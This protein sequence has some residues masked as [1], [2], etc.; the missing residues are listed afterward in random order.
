MRDGGNSIGI[1]DMDK[2]AQVQRDNP[3]A[4]DY[5]ISLLSHR[6][7]PDTSQRFVTLG[8]MPADLPNIEKLVEYETQKHGKCGCGRQPI[9]TFFILLQE[10]PS[11]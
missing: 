6:S 4:N 7:L 8:N 3:N 11:G 10:C 9:A 5:L 1:P 2:L